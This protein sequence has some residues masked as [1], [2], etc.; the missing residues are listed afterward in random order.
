[1][2]ARK[3]SGPRWIN[4]RLRFPA[5]VELYDNTA[6]LQDRTVDTGVLKPA[7]AKQ[8]AAGGYVGRASGRSFDA[9]R[10]PGLSAV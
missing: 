5:L 10:S 7:L 1:M 9:R 2:K 8:Y 6:S 3:S 4:I